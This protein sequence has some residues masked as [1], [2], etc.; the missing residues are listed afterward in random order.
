MAKIHI[1]NLGAIHSVSMEIKQFNLFIGEQATGKSTL[2]KA[3]YYF[4]NFKEILLEHLYDIILGGKKEHK[5][6][7]ALNS[8]MKDE[9]IKLFGY[10]WEL[11]DNLY[12]CYEYSKLC[13]MEVRLVKEKKKY[14]SL[15]YN[16]HLSREIQ[17]LERLAV[18]YHSMLSGEDMMSP[19]VITEQRSFFSGLKEKVTILLND[20]MTTYYIPAGR[21]MLSLLANQKT[22]LNYE[23]MEPLNRK[24]MQLI[25]SMQPK[26]KEGLTQVHK[27]YSTDSRKF[28]VQNM[29]ESIVKGIKGEYFY[30]GTREYF[31]MENKKERVPVEFGG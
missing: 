23:D 22:K 21:S 15:E 1:N 8:K 10:S 30:Q 3:V 28:D 20:D 27:F 2:C 14:L 18:N 7:K 4:R 25:E 17:A 26:F 31:L 29:S 24:F 16:D 9:F 13:T 12:I 11:P 19:H 5:F 6:P